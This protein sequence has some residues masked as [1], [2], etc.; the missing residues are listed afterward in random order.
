MK[1][2]AKSAGLQGNKTNHSAKKTMCARLI[3]Q[4]VTPTHVAQLSGHKNLKSLDSYATA[5]TERQKRMSTILSRVHKQ[6]LINT[7]NMTISSLSSA[8]SGLSGVTVTGNQTVNV[9]VKPGS[10]TYSY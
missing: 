4:N 8:C 10:L 3:S 9:C 7:K 2:M 5:S 6:P 1:T